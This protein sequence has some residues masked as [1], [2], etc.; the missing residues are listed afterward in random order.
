MAVADVGAADAAGCRRLGAVRLQASAAACLKPFLILCL[1]YVGRV[2]QARRVLSL[3]AASTSQ[4]AGKMASDP[5][6]GA[7]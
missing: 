3:T 1:A 5:P 7:G 6:S 4:L 2:R